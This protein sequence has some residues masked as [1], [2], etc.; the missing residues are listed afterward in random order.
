MNI[1]VEVQSGL[2][3][4][5]AIR[6]MF[7]V[8][9]SAVLLLPGFT[10]AMRT[11]S[12]KYT[13]RYALLQTFGSEQ[14]QYTTEA[15][16]VYNPNGGDP[17]RVFCEDRDGW[18]APTDVCIDCTSGCHQCVGDKGTVN[19]ECGGQGKMYVKD[20]ICDPSNRDGQDSIVHESPSCQS[21]LS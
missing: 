8:M 19:I 7:F 12:Q 1:K 10:H 11:C 15:G 6:L 16:G 2:V 13:G 17:V 9:L 21:H 4:L 3:S 14:Q 20:I 18:Y 5:C